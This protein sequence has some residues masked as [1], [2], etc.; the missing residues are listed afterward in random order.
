MNKSI[1]SS[2]IEPQF[3]PANKPRTLNVFGPNGGGKGALVEFLQAQFGYGVYSMSGDGLKKRKDRIVEVSPKAGS[4]VSGER[5]SIGDA[6]INGRLPVDA[7]INAIVD[8]DISAIDSNL[9]IAMDGTCRTDV[10]A[11]F[12]LDRVLPKMARADDARGLLLD[13]PRERATKQIMMR[14]LETGRI[15]DQNPE[16]VNARLS[17]YFEKTV[18]AVDLFDHRGL[19]LTING[20][21]GFDP[22]EA[23]DILV[24]MKEL[25]A[26]SD[27]QSAG[28]LRELEQQFQDLK[29]NKILPSMQEVRS[30]FM[31]TLA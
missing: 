27:I 21:T 14:G 22:Q 9:H 5:M 15:D 20:T 19:L 24:E 6:M 28:R 7:E 1:K 31:A 25:R 23:I 30:R 8:E 26:K 2:S 17:D 10:Q 16:V 13:V 12:M 3:Q 29:Q 4:E 11:L 18:R